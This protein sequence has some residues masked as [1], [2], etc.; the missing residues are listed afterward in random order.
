MT[1]NLKQRVEDRIRQILSGRHG[2]IPT[3]SIDG[4]NHAVIML[5]VDPALGPQL[6]PLRQEIERAILMI[7]DIKKVH[8]ILTA[9]TKPTGITP[10]PDPHGMNKN[11]VLDIPAKKIIVVASGKGGVGKSTVAVNLA[12]TLAKTS[13]VGLLDADIYGP[14]QPTMLGEVNYKPVLNHE[15]KFIP[16]MKYGLKMMSIGFLTEAGQAL[17]WRGPMAQTA[18]YQMLRDVAW[19]AEDGTPLDY[20]IIDMPPGTG[21]VQLTL[22]QKVKA[23]GAVIVSTP[24]DI[25]LIDSRRAFAMFQKTN[26]P[27]LGIVE[28]MSVHICSNCGHADHIF[29]DSGAEAEAQ[30]LNIP[31]LGKIPLDRAIRENADNGTP[32]TIS[33]PQHPATNAYSAIANLLK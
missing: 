30:K 31:F 15:R 20:L 19:A 22:A 26:I 12:V 16:L 7:D 4:N 24:Q 11:P 3:I 32:I 17:I 29:G 8:A 21:D 1:V 23:D 33:A 18:F 2:I 28:N 9:H 6:E 14:S 13:K 10:A 5:E 25:A 27:I